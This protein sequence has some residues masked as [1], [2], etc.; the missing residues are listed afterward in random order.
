MAGYAR[1]STNFLDLNSHF[2]CLKYLMAQ[3]SEILIHMKRESSEPRLEAVCTRQKKHHL[4]K[5]HQAKNALFLCAR[6]D[7]GTTAK[8]GDF[9]MPN[10]S[11]QH[12]RFQRL[13]A[14]IIPFVMSKCHISPQFQEIFSYQETQ[15]PVVHKREKMNLVRKDSDRKLFETFYVQ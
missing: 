11:C 5:L 4:E 13:E 7:L 1:P 9:L 3:R 15:R 12:E 2:T 10:F 8:F 14:P 6:M